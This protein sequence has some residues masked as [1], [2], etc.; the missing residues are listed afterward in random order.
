MRYIKTIP[1]LFDTYIFLNNRYI[2][3]K[4]QGKVKKIS[5]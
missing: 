1:K 3:A 4:N 2:K 5:N